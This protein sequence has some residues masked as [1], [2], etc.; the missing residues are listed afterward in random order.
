MIRD[1]KSWHLGDTGVLSNVHILSFDFE[2]KRRL[3]RELDSLMKEYLR[4]HSKIPALLY[5]QGIFDL[6]PGASDFTDRLSV[7]TSGYGLP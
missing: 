7:A 4:G 5:L 2:D 6:K 1:L 3:E